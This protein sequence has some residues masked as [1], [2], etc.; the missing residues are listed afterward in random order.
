M[1]VPT[2]KRAGEPP[3]LIRLPSLRVVLVAQPEYVDVDV[4]RAI[5]REAEEPGSMAG[6]RASAPRSRGTTASTLT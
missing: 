6:P 3:A 2:E 5:L 4:C 1:R